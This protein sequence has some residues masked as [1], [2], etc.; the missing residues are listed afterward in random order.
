MPGYVASAGR[1][2]LSGH[3][4][5][6]NAAREVIDHVYGGIHFRFKQDGGAEQ[7]RRVGDYGY[8]NNLR[9]TSACNCDGRRLSAPNKAG[10]V[11]AS[12]STN[13]GVYAITFRP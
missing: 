6:T 2:Y 7:G 5:L 11:Y 9:R 8:T 10:T 1:G 4:T 13:D 12:T 3:A